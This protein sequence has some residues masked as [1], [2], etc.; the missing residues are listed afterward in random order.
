[1]TDPNAEQPSA[2]TPDAR[3]FAPIGVVIPAYNAERF[4]AETLADVFAWLDH[5]GIKAEVLVVDDGSTDHTA[6]RVRRFGRPVG[7]IRL[8][9]NR[10]KGHA[11]RI[12]M[13]A[14]IAALSDGAQHG[15]PASSRP[16]APRDSG[17][18][19]EPAGPAA[20]GWLGGWV[21]FL[22]ADNSTPIHHLERFAQHAVSADVIIGT[23]RAPQSRIVTRQHP[24]RQILGRTFPYVVRVLCLPRLGD[25]QCGFKAFR[26]SIARRIFAA[27]TVDRFAFDVEILLIAQR[28][29]ARIR[30]VPVDWQN[31]TQSTLKIARDAPRMLYDALRAAWRWREGSGS[32]R[33]LRDGRSIGP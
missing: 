21:L 29:G 19:G 32:V 12:G 17:A 10:G 22:D 6:E 5:A 20:G 18:H 24:L 2:E 28:L 33:R 4:I 14:V 13:N 30:E 9:Q 15:S 23:R 25:T 11:V 31:P 16:D 27:Q 7:L 3:L 8:G 1:M 26:I